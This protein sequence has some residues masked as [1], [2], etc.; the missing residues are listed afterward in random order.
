MW[1]NPRILD[2]LAYFVQS[3][4]KKTAKENSLVI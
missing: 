1:S 4:I 3:E 2:M